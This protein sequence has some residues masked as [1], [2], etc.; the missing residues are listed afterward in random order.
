MRLS[1]FHDV[2]PD[3]IG[4]LS[5]RPAGK[6]VFPRVTDESAATRFSRRAIDNAH[7]P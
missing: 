6:G 5:R 2:Q 3:G 1:H 7:K 4:Y